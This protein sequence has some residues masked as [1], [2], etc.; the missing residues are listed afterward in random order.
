L[1]KEFI[2]HLRKKDGKPQQLWTHLEEVAELA[3][4]FAAKVGLNKCGELIGL[5]HDVGKASKEFQDYLKSAAGEI[6]PDEDEY[7]NAGAKKGKIDHSTAGAQIIYQHLSQKSSEGLFTAQILSLCIVSH[8]GL[9]IIDC[10]TPDGEDNF[11]RRISKATEKTHTNEARLNLCDDQKDRIGSLLSDESL[12]GNLIAKLKSLREENDNAD[13]LNFKFGLLLR[14]LFSCLIDADRISTADFE[15]PSNKKLRN[16]NRHPSWEILVERFDK[17]KFDSTNKVDILRSRVSQECFDFSTRQKGL[18]QLTVPTGGGKTFASLRFALNHAKHHKI[19]RIFYIIP[20]TS[21]ID[22]NAEE[23]RKILEEKDG[24]GKQ[25]DKVVLEHHSNLTPDE[26]TKRQNLLSEN[27]DAPIIFTTQVQFLEA[28]FSAGTRGARRMHQLA[29]SVIIF[30]EVQTI[31][32][33]C[34]HLFNLAIRFLVHSCGS[35]V[36]LCTAT[37]P[38]LDEVEPKQRSLIIRSEQKMIED[39]KSL[40]QN[41]K[42]VTVHDKRKAGNWSEKQVAKLVKKEVEKSD[43]VLIIV[44]TKSSAHNLYEEL[45]KNKSAKVFHLSTNMCPAH[46][47]D[48]LDEIKARLI[49]KKPTICVSTQLIEAGVDIDFGSV[50]RYLAGLDSIAQAAGRCN[51]HGLRPTGNVY[52]VNPEDENLDRLRDIREGKDIAQRALDDHKTNPEKFDKDILSPVAMNEYYKYYF[53]RRKEEMNYP[54]NSKLIGVDDNLFRLLSTNDGEPLKEYQ[55]K[56]TGASPAIPLK[57]SFQSA[58]KAFRVID[59]PT[60]GIVVPYGKGGGEIINELCSAFDLEKQ[61]HLIRKAQRYSVNVYENVFRQLAESKAIHEAQEGIG[62][63][64]LKPEYYSDEIG[65]STEIV[66]EPQSFIV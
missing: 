24:S 43:S 27:W 23:V 10:L 7:V 56:H 60:Q 46:R 45:K 50:V 31:S 37:Q 61:Y 30:D 47:K 8:H 54:V 58:A 17:K 55:R 18:Y 52:I 49:E 29:N 36:V 65:L 34:V 39:V 25:L 5:L 9:G 44:N 66:N 11:T 38:L 2:A 4:Q 1:N 12:V 42:R 48:F 28:L 15:F 40:F 32:V 21:I 35:T 62:V 59:S 63:F 6:N 57:Q 19:D 14:F 33:R 64:Y 16:E 53:Y 20:Y 3:G 26:E 41:L 13:T 51:R 22:Q